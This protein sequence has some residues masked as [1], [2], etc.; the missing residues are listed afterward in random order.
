[1]STN[2]T[3]QVIPKPAATDLVRDGDDAMRALVDRID[4]LLGEGGEWTSPA[5]AGTSNA[6]INLQRAYP[7]GFYVVVSFKTSR[8]A[9]AG[10]CWA[11]QL[12]TAGGPGGVAQLTI[13]CNLTAATAC[14]LT[15]TIKPKPV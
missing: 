4:Y 15:Y 9:G 10:S 7:Q 1:M 5:A 8:V 11:F 12:S 6:N 3:V 14:T 13:G 2:T